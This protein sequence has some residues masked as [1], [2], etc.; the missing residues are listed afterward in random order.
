[1]RLNEFDSQILFDLY[2]TLARGGNLHSYLSVGK[3]IDWFRASFNVKPLSVFSGHHALLY[4][5]SFVA[6]NF[7]TNEYNIALSVFYHDPETPEDIKTYILLKWGQN[8][9]IDS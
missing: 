5:Q 9:A 3:R 1:M 4:D 7:E 2:L 8:V 6:N